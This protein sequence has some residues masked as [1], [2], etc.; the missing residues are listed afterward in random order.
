[1]RARRGSRVASLVPISL[2]ALA[3]AAPGQALFTR[4]SVDSQGAPSD[5]D[6]E[7]PV[8]SRDGRFVAFSSSATNLVASDGNHVFDVFVHDLATGATVRVSVSSSGT[9]SNRNCGS[10]SITGDGR[11]VVFHTDAS[12]LV[13]GDTNGARDVFVHD[14]D[15]D[16]NGVFDEGNG[17]TERVSVTAGGAQANSGSFM[18]TITVDGRFVAFA[19][20]ASNLVSNDLNGYTDVFVKDRTTGTVTCVSVDGNGDTRHGV[21]NDPEISDDGNAVAFAS[22]SPFLVAND[23]NATEDVF[24]RDLVAGVTTR[25]SVDSAGV[26]GNGVSRH[27]ALSPD[28]LIVAFDSFASNLVPGDQNRNVDVFVHEMATATTTRASVDAAGQETWGFSRAPCV[29]ADGSLV[30]FTSDSSTY[31]LGDLLGHHDVF[32]KDRTT[33]IVTI[34][35][36]GCGTFGDDDSGSVVLSG[37]GAV[38]SFET[39]ATDFVS[40]DSGYFQDIYVRDRSRPD[41]IAASASYGAGFAG[42]LGVPTLAAS[43]PPVLGTSTTIDV[44]S[45]Y[46]GWTVG[47]VFVGLSQASLSLPYG[48]TLLV[49]DLVLPL[50]PITIAPALDSIP[51]DVPAHPWVAGAIVELQVVELDPGASHGLAFTPGLELEFGG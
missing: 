36:G 50:V 27:P 31:V 38:A 34:V 47:F 1:M 45:S 44:G 7:F 2:A 4:A 42:S 35:S 43:A 46:G 5:N 16:G 21:S 17:T 10:P 28:G 14:R 23:N 12:N 15:P 40:G 6:S 8:L 11:L 20:A 30:G 3:A 25:V 37:D 39:R 29:T 51:L 41:P 19:S 32:V 49:G 9:E 22:E 13:A 26:E 24:L 18:P 33:G 48:A